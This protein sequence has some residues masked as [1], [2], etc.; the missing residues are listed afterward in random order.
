ME[1]PLEN[2]GHSTEVWVFPNVGTGQSDPA[3]NKTA[4][5]VCLNVVLGIL[6]VV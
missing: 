2:E 6:L 4:T 5:Q 3:L 1:V